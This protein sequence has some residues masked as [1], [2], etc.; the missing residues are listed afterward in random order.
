MI[1]FWAMLECHVS[2]ILACLPRVRIFF[3]RIYRRFR[4][5]ESFEYSDSRQP[6]EAVSDKRLVSESDT[7][8][9]EKGIPA[10]RMSSERTEESGH[11][12]GIIGWRQE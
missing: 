3:I 10:V 1:S 7:L 4:P 9:R 5:A 11:G 8:D 2:I 6:P 12:D